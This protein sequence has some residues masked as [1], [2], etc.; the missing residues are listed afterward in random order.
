MIPA[1]GT[2][3]A[4]I[5]VRFAGFTAETALLAAFQ[6]CGPGLVAAALVRVEAVRAA[7]TVDQVAAQLPQWT[8][9]RS[10]HL[11]LLVPS[12]LAFLDLASHALDLLLF[13]GSCSPRGGRVVTLRPALRVFL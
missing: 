8:A 2:E 6:H 7:Q 10:R 11:F 13:G 3:R 9:P 5:R 4:G 1:S 12:L